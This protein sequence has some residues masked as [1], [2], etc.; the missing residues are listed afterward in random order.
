MAFILKTRLYRWTLISIISILVSILFSPHPALAQ[1]ELT[2]MS[3]IPVIISG[4]TLTNAWAGGLNCPQFSPIDLNGDSIK[5]LFI[6]ERGWEGKVLTFLNNG[7]PD[8]IDYVYAPEYESKFPKISYWALLV[9]YNCD[10]MEDIFTSVSG[11]MAV[12]RNDYD[13][14]DGLQFT[15]ITPLLYTEGWS[16]QVNLLVIS[17]DIPAIVD[18]D[19]DGDLDIITFS[20][21]STMVEY[22]KNYSIENYGNCDSLDYIKETACWGLFSED[23]LNSDILL[24]ISCKTVK[25]LA[26]PVPGYTSTSLMPVYGS[27]KQFDNFL[28]SD[29]EETQFDNNSKVLHA[30]STL[31]ALD[32]D[33]DSD[34]DLIIGDIG[35]NN[36]V[37]LTN[38]GDS[39]NALM[40]SVIYD[41]P[42]SKPVDLTSFPASYYLDVNNDGLKDLL[43]APNDN[44]IDMSDNFSSVWYYKNIGSVNA[45]VFDFQDSF[46]LQGGMIEVGSGA[47]PVFFDYNADGLLDIVIGNY[48]YYNGF[49]GML[50]LYKNIGTPTKP[51][52]ELITRDF[53]NT[54]TIEQRGL[55]PA[56]G[57]LDNDGDED[58]LLGDW[59]GSLYYY[60]N[61]AGAGNTV[62]F[63]LTQPN[64]MGIDV[65]QYAAP[66]IIDVN[67]DGISDLLIGERKGN[68]NYFEN[69][70]TITSPLFDSIPTNDSLGK[71][72][73]IYYSTGYST[74]FMTCLDSSGEYYLL[75]GSVRG[76]IYLYGNIDN[77]LTGAFT[78]ID[79]IVS[80][81]DIGERTTISGADINNDGILEFIIGNSRGGVTVFSSNALIVSIPGIEI[82]N[83]EA[84]YSDFVIFPNPGNGRIII[85]HASTLKS[86]DLV[87]EVYD[88]LGR[89]LYIPLFAIHQ[90][91]IIL[92][93]TDNLP[94]VYFCRIILK[95]GRAFVKKIV[96]Y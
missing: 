72:D 36:L 92:D 41:F 3:S 20:L 7:T 88:I 60:E 77:N 96:V 31:L 93:F 14:I 38:G 78:L 13:T 51:V 81:I 17:P 26:P 89:E 83:N 43:V 84:D 47:N 74:P 62:N 32:M 34:K 9:D 56:F 6:Y 37:F 30:G 68:L 66:Q 48:G 80:S 94:S 91:H 95:D 59:D 61:T 65:G 28:G 16:G 53:A 27:G 63:V 19:N 73:V 18:M 87:I 58:M 15:L 29:S 57:D 2:R 46:F 82:E 35:F 12:Y 23:I 45:P 85:K 75:I 8:S 5:D 40:V 10:G 90:N 33:G 86:R 50:S 52:Y 54:S 70:G 71:V 21:L 69:T 11:G 64:Y 67:R 42:P 24:G 44:A 25:M 76:Y 49:V 55:Y 4:D 1:F 79:S 39:L 22:H